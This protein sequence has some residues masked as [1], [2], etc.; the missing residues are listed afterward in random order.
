[1]TFRTQSTNYAGER[2]NTPKM[3]STGYCEIVLLPAA[4]YDVRYTPANPVIGFAF[5]AQSGVHAFASDRTQPFRT[6]PNSIAYI[7]AGCEV[8]SR[9]ASGGEY[10]TLTVGDVYDVA[11]RPVC[12]FNDR[13]D[14]DAIKAA[15]KL[16]GI[17]LAN[18]CFDGLEVEREV[19]KLADAVYKASGILEPL[20]AERWMTP[21]RLKQVDDFIQ[22]NLANA[23]PVEAIATSLGLSAGFFSRAFKAATGK[24]P[25]DYI[26]DRRISRARA[27]IVQT[28][29][30]LARVATECGFASQ[31]HMTTQMKRRLSITPA[32]LRMAM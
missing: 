3:I 11:A 24:S 25:H 21:R 27:L 30:E 13:I 17:I 4:A 1:M 5:E 18:L 20:P 15:E 12:R 23:M 19:L 22:S 32:R 16:R 10:L 29:L 8:I 28:D 9:S 6:R 14:A 31:A 26:L 7:P 2:R